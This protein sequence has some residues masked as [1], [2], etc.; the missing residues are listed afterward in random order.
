GYFLASRRFYPPPEFLP[1]D[2]TVVQPQDSVLIKPDS[3]QTDTVPD[4]KTKIKKQE[5]I[6]KTVE[7]SQENNTETEEEQPVRG[8]TPIAD[9]VN[10]TNEAEVVL[11]V[12]R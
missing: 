8:L 4:V 6:K 2:T 9:T 12:M 10:I 3:I 11:F 7:K 1:A 5:Q